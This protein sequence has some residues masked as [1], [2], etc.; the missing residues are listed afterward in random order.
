[1]SLKST[2]R[3]K[4]DNLIVIAIIFLTINRVQKFLIVTELP[5][6]MLAKAFVSLFSFGWGQIIVPCTSVFMLHP[7]VVSALTIPVN[8]FLSVICRNCCVSN[9]FPQTG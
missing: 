5:T 2:N 8:R 6:A 3:Q 4:I 7:F 9:F 1:M